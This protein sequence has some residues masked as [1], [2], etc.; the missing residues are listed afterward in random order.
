MRAS[1]SEIMLLLANHVSRCSVLRTAESINERRLVDP[2][3]RFKRPVTFCLS[4]AGGLTQFSTLR[5][6]LRSPLSSTCFRSDPET[7]P[8]GLTR[9]K[10]SRT[11]TIS[12]VRAH[13]LDCSYAHKAC[14]R[15][16]R[17]WAHTYATRTLRE[18]AVHHTSRKHVFKAHNNSADR[19]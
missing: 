8:H 12:I 11:S 9:T 18:R 5:R 16:A 4:Q 6:R 14:A 7:A 2:L 19:K 10:P 1:F 13:S 17:A 3:N 15:T